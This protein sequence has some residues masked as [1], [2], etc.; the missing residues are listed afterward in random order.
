MMTHQNTHFDAIVI[1]AGFAGIYMLHKLRNELGLRVRAFDKAGGV[2]GTWWWNKY[3]GAKADT[4]SFVYRYSFDKDTFD[5]WQWQNRYATQPEMQAY[6]HAVAERHGLLAHIQLNTAI[7][8]ASFDTTRNLWKVVTAAAE[9]FTARYLVCAVGVLSRVNIPQI[10]G[11]QRFQGRIVHT[12]G[13]PSDLALA[14]KRVGVFGT[15]STGVQ[16]ICAAA[17]E[18]EHLTVFQRSAQYCVPAG[19]RQVTEDHVAQY[20][21]NFDRVWEQI[22]NTRIACGFEESS[23][24]AMSLS[25]AE[26]ERVFEQHWQRGNGF[27]FMFG[28]FCDLAVDPAANQAAAD[29]ISAKIRQIVKDPQTARKLIPTEFYAKRPVCMDG[30]YETFNR[31]N[32]TLVSLT[33]TPVKE[34][35]RNGVLTADGTEHRLDVLV[36]ATGFE[37]IEGSYNLMTIQGRTGET[38]QDHWKDQPKSYLGIATSGF[39]N[40]FMV[41]GPNSAFSN[42]PPSIET[43]VEFIAEL[44]KV[45]DGAAEPLIEADKSAEDAWTEQCWQM[46]SYTLF[47]KVKS[48]IFGENIPG[49]QGRVLFFFG[50]LAAYRQKL[51]ELAESDYGGF[52]INQPP[53]P[54]TAGS[55]ATPVSLSHT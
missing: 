13:W 44:I 49:K 26:R 17:R 50:G 29:F 6:L 52:L 38:L 51:R 36:Y 32:V 53:R 21:A 46:A 34:I 35:T 20:R 10:S 47:S 27:E 12:A 28:T 43:Q 25:A 1:G 41:L 30:Y 18:A 45:A 55:E 22:R 23:I 39:P 19:D 11:M 4:E 31:D 15:G 9:Q 7:E 48:W 2:G 42:L 5:G 8:S 14:G 3:P 37:T 16:F 33:E 24:S 54:R 40:L